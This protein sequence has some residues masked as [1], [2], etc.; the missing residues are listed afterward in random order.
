[1]SRLETS[2]NLQHRQLL[3]T[4]I[5][6]ALPGPCPARIIRTLSVGVKSAG[7]LVAFRYI[8]AFPLREMFV[9]IRLLWRLQF[10]DPVKNFIDPRRNEFMI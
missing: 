10:V 1:L 5:R 6:E 9:V 2:E 8:P 3:A 7:T 4:G